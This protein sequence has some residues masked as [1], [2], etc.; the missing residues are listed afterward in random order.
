MST[1]KGLGKGFDVLVPVGL[2]VQGV[3][4]QPQERVR[5]LAVDIVKPKAD[6]PRQNF[7]NQALEQLAQSVKQHGIMQPIIVIEI[8]QD[9]YSIIAGERRWRA[10]QIAG[11]TEVP[12]IVRTATE[13]QQLELA[14]LENVQRE[15]LG[16]LE[17]ATAVARLHDQFGQ[18]YASIAKSLGKAETTVNNIVRLLGLP[19]S[20][21]QALA[22]GQITE[23]HARA[24]LSLQQLPKAQEVLFGQILRHGW[25]VRQAESFA[26]AAKKAGTG[27]PKKLT[28]KE[29][30]KSAERS[31]KLI[32]DRLNLPVKVQHTAKGGKLV[33]SFKSDDDLARIA[34]QIQVP[35]K[36]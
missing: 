18:S 15:D 34:E 23:G 36:P 32:T 29:L 9:L 10:A 21:K 28:K 8:E 33:I 7:D 30:A 6:Q 14:L 2:D 13:H 11:L 4:A 5:R 24:L 12:A 16:A 19:V 35:R 25:N 31:L 20:M 26:G 3:A 22:N 1:R 17:T 27:T